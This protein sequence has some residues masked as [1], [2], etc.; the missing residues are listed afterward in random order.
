MKL[1]TLK[2]FNGLLTVLTPYLHRLRFTIL[3]SKRFCKNL[4]FKVICITV[5]FVAAV[6]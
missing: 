6:F 5:S 1:C 4:V 3:A 2:Q